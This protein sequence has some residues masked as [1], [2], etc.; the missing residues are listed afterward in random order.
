MHANVEV[1]LKEISSP[2]LTF[3]L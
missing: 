1:Y 3:C 2:M